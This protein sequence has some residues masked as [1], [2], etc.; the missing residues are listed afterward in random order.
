MNLGYLNLWPLGGHDPPKDPGAA[1]S[2]PPLRPLC[3]RQLDLLHRP[4]RSCSRLIFTSFYTRK[5]I[6]CFDYVPA[7][8]ILE[9][10][11]YIIFFI[12]TSIII[13][14]SHCEGK[15]ACSLSFFLMPSSSW[16]SW[17]F[18]QKL[19]FHCLIFFLVVWHNQQDLS[20]QPKIFPFW[21]N[22]CNKP[23]FFVCLNGCKNN[24]GH[25][26]PLIDYFVPF[27]Y[28]RLLFCFFSGPQLCVVCYWQAA[29]LSLWL[30]SKWRGGR[31]GGSFII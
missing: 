20:P 15:V 6:F 11:V 7:K 19:F 8:I 27:L 1:T 26:H 28:F 18:L 24:Q 14:I 21:K 5:A 30:T 25:S 9:T 29:V 4:S 2:L 23:Q 17:W 3:H 31:L 22:I 10:T 12:S 16:S 13:L